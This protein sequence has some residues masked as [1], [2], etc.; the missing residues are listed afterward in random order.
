MSMASEKKL[1]SDQRLLDLCHE[2]TNIYKT[3]PN[4]IPKE[5]LKEASSL[6]SV[7]E[8]H[9]FGPNFK[10]LRDKKI[11]LFEMCLLDISMGGDMLRAGSFQISFKNGQL[12]CQHKY[13]GD[14]SDGELVYS[15]SLK[16]QV[17]FQ[18]FKKNE[19][20]EIS[21]EHINQL[22]LYFACARAV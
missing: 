18:G 16:N 21:Q 6:V 14:A 17:A 1:K 20:D 3:H 11:E 15:V 12:Q 10:N 8:N 19:A 13:F 7:F 9:Q 22:S 4:S 2:I 5:A